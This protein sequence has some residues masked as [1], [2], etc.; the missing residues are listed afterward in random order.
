[1]VL[2][3]EDMVTVYGQVVA[4]DIFGDVYMIPLHDIIDDIQTLLN[5]AFVTPSNSTRELE[6]ILSK[7]LRREQ[8]DQQAETD[9]KDMLDLTTDSGAGRVE[10]S[11]TRA[12]VNNYSCRPEP[13][14]PPHSAIS[15]N[16]GA[17]IVQNDK[18]W[19]ASPA[20]AGYLDEYDNDEKV[21]EDHS[22]KDL[23]Y[24][25][26]RALLAEEKRKQ[27]PWTAK[28]D[29]HLKNQGSR[30][31]RGIEALRSFQVGPKRF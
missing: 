13:N 19:R 10:D 4:D 15:E 27:A 8:A 12:S 20:A 16:F 22:E 31:L 17:F 5:T 23:P 26:Y 1:M 29:E 30:S 24:S 3:G 21:E 18:R 7:Q 25:T 28:E 2:P 6:D 9:S 11:S 14:I